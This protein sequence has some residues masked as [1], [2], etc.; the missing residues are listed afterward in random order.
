MKVNYPT[1]QINKKITKPQTHG[2]LFENALNETNLYYLHKNKAVIYKKPTPI[3]VVKVHYPERS[4][5]KIV[6]AYYKMPSTTD[7]NGIY[8]GRYI[9]Y[10]AKETNNL[11]FSFKHIFLHQIEHL[12]KIDEHGGIAFIIIYFKKVHEVYLL[13]IKQFY[14]LYQLSNEGGHKSITIEQ[15]KTLGK[16]VKIGYCPTIDY[17]QAIDE[18]YFHKK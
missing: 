9:D 10:E 11:S 12:R 8:R 17:L 3:Q 7:Y 1:P 13:D 2:M 18:L 15:F 5:A 4:K 16:Q 6:E 14:E